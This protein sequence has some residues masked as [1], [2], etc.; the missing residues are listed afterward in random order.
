MPTY[1]RPPI[2]EA[3]I[4]INF[5]K[6]APREKVEK[7]GGRLKRFY[8]NQ[9][10]EEHAEFLLQGGSKPLPTPEFKWGGLRLSSDDRADVALLRSTVLVCSRLAPYNG[11]EGFQHRAIR[12]WKIWRKAVGRLKISRIGVRFINR[13]DIPAQDS[14]I[15]IEDFLRISM[16]MPQFQ[17]KP[18]E[19]YTIQVQRPLQDG[20]KLILNSGSVRS[21]LLEH[22]SFLLDIDVCRDANLPQTDKDVWSL[23]SEMR[24]V[25]N[26]IFEASITD[27]ARELFS[28]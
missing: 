16:N 12:D 25:K 5:E 10:A 4:A 13:I 6:P 9:D 28:R 1:N 20:L 22:L 11:W 18:I 15:R 27:A 8:A 14:P 2:T 26:A 7:A 21:P 17:W 19:A 3:V 23:V 24:D